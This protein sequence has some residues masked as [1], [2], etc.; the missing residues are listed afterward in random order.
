MKNRHLLVLAC[1]LTAAALLLSACGKAPTPV[2]EQRPVRTLTVG[3]SPTSVDNRYAGEVRARHES[4]LAFRVGGKITARKVEVGAHV[5]KGELLFQ[6][7]NADYALGASAA[8]AQVAAAQAQLRAARGDLQRY[9]DLLAQKYISQSEFDRQ[10]AAFDGAMAN[11]A[12]LTAQSEQL[13]NQSHYTG[14]YADGDGIVAAVL[15]EAGQVAGPGTPVV[16]IALDG[17]LEVALAIPEDQ[18][19]AVKVGAPVT[20]SLWAQAQ[21][22]ELPATVREISAAADPYTR[23]YAARVSVANTPATMR[24]GMTATVTV[25]QAAPALLHL[26]AAAMVTHGGKVGVWVYA[27]KAQTVA[28]HPVQYAGVDGNS[29][30]ISAGLNPGDTVVTAGAGFLSE[31]QKVRPL[32]AVGQ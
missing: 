9:R 18:V 22:G 8:N 26:P 17:Q 1:P 5:R 7:D 14:L 16:R 13:Q 6:M 31:G 20:V 19:A 28:F 23:T 15:A 27:D 21:L 11:V 25:P 30:V 12:G 32:P 2:V 4:T 3:L 10:Q 29:V 24:I